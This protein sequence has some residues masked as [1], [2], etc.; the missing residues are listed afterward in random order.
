MEKEIPLFT[1]E[2]IVKE[3]QIKG[4]YIK[5]DKGKDKYNGNS[6]IYDLLKNMEG[7]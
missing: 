1:R 2:E 3:L 5:E 4:Y 6:N 7:Y